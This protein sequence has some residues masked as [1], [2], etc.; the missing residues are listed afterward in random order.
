[1]IFRPSQRRY[2]FGLIAAAMATAGQG[3]AYQPSFHPDR[4]KGPPVGAPNDVMILASP[5]LSEL[6]NTFAP[7]MVTPLLMRLA[8]WQPTAIATEDMPGLQ[9]DS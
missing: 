9:C 4:L 2:V 8:S 1:M 3:Q 5:H 6:P 7:N